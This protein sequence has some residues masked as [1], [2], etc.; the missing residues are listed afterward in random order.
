MHIAAGPVEDVGSW[1]S[2]LALSQ[3][4]QRRSSRIGSQGQARKAGQQRSG[5]LPWTCN[6]ARTR[7]RRTR[8]L[9]PMLQQANAGLRNRKTTWTQCI[10]GAEQVRFFTAAADNPR[11]RMRGFG[12]RPTT[13]DPSSKQVTSKS[14][15]LHVAASWQM[16]SYSGFQ[17]VSRPKP[18]V[19]RPGMREIPHISAPR[20]STL[21]L[22]M[23]YYA[24]AG[25]RETPCKRE[26][27]SPQ[28]LRLQRCSFLNDGAF[29]QFQRV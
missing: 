17:R 1:N 20:P 12:Q 15:F 4:T 19:P 9:F 13:H 29:Q 2:G 28:R 21:H 10:C 11:P 14:L 5:S 23:R 24:A 7:G 26:G 22:L 16:V 3:E 27:P 6:L 18:P 8:T 25:L